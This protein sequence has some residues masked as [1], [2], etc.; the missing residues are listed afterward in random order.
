MSLI[1]STVST[2]TLG[3][4]TFG[5]DDLVEYD[6]GSDT[7]TLF[8]DGLFAGN[9]DINALHVLSDGH[10]ILSTTSGATIGGM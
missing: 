7:A 2:A 3:G 8:F 10:I 1:L 9:E 4:L 6:P 5:D